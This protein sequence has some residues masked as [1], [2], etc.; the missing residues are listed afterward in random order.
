MTSVDGR[1]PSESRWRRRRK[2]AAPSGEPMTYARRLGIY[3]RQ[4]GAWRLTP[5]QRRRINHKPAGPA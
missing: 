2:A 3:Y 1:R 5:A 4:N